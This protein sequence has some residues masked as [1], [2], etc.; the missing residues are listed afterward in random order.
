VIIPALSPNFQFTENTEDENKQG[1]K[2]W[3]SNQTDTEPENKCTV[4]DI[5]IPKQH[6]I[7]NAHS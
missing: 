3:R 7:L 1:W 6:I 4:L 2:I 5:K